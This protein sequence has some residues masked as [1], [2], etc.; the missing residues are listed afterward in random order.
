M[1]NSVTVQQKPLPIKSQWFYE[2]KEY[3]QYCV[4][5]YTEIL[6]IVDIHLKGQNENEISTR[7]TEE[8]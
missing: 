1:K 5:W 8:M 7:L 4:Y 3:W 2:V 6:V